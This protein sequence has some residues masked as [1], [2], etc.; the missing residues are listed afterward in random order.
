[1]LLQLYTSLVQP[2]VEYAAS[3]WDPHLQ[4]D[5]QLL[6]KTQKFACRMCTKTWD[7]GCEELLSTLNLP[8]LSN[9]RLFLKLCIVFKIIHNLCNFPP[10]V[11]STRESRLYTNRTFM[12]TQVLIHSKFN[13][14]LELFTSTCS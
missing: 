14:S 12:L 1:M 13:F 11:L 6:E 10:G 8:S 7:V 2:H 4:W 5:I 9:R 3:V